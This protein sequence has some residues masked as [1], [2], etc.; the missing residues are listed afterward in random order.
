MNDDNKKWQAAHTK[1]LSDTDKNDL[2]TWQQ[3]TILD[4]DIPLSEDSKP[5]HAV[6]VTPSSDNSTTT[7]ARLNS[8]LFTK[9]AISI[10][11][12]FIAI[13]SYDSITFV[14]QVMQHNSFAGI[15]FSGLFASV[16]FF[17]GVICWK[18]YK[19]IQLLQNIN[20]LQQFYSQENATSLTTHNQHFQQ[21]LQLYQYKPAYVP[22]IQE[23][24]LAQQAHHDQ[25]DNFILFQR[26]ILTPLDEKAQHIILKY[27]S[28][29]AIAISVSPMASLDM[30]FSLWRNLRMIREIAKL[31][32]VHPGIFGSLQLAKAVT[33]NL[34]FTGVSEL[35]TEAGSSV[36][37]Q[38]SGAIMSAR[39]GQGLG[40]GILTAKVG[41][42]ALQYCRP[43]PLT[44]EITLSQ[45]IQH[46][47]KKFIQTLLPS[48]VIPKKDKPVA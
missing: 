48:G 47:R 26:I 16:F 44:K 25:E 32:G 13:L 23:Y 24:Q 18:E 7:T 6:T 31:Y 29:T 20:H 22:L 10:A 46:L 40:A 28:Q 36:F 45:L 2:P 1:T 19:A 43:I 4:D 41:L 3:A 27:S 12:L 21:L 5:H 37:A 11:L 33:L 42:K 34:V 39:L 30:L 14:L 9:L 17:L 15:L 38:S 8:H 35:V